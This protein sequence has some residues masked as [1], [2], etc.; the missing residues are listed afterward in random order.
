MKG[1]KDSNQVCSG[2]DGGKGSLSMK[3]E[4]NSKGSLCLCCPMSQLLAASA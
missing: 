2:E 4:D 3:L 1:Q